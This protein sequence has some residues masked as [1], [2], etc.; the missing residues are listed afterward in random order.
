MEK[1]L[2]YASIKAQQRYVVQVSPSCRGIN[3][4]TMMTKA[5]M[6]VPKK[7]FNA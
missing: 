3:D 6:P 2:I 1:Y 4:T 5:K 7:A